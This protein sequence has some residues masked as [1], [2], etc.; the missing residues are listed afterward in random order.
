M[1]RTLKSDKTL[2]L[3][4]LL[5][6]GT[7]M[8]MVYSASAVQA[9]AEYQSQAFFL[10]KQAAWAALGLMTMLV[11]M[12][13]DYRQYRRPAVIWSLVAVAAVLLVAV[14]LFPARNNAQRWI[15]FGSV[16]MQPSE[17]AKLAAILFTVAVLDRRMHRVNHVGYALAP[18]A[19]VAGG[20]ATLIV[21]EPDLGSA[22]VLVGVVVTVVFAAGLSYRYLFGTVLVLVPV[23]GAFLIGSDFRRRRIA[24]FLNPWADPLGDGYQI[25]NSLIAIGSGGLIGKGLGGGLQKL[26][27]IPEPHTDFIY[28]VIAEEFGLIGTTLTLLCFVL[29]AWRGFRASLVAPDRF[30]ALLALGLTSMIVLQACVN[31]SVVISLLPT[32]GIPLPFVSSG[33]SSLI[34]NLIA[35]GV[36]LNISQQATA[37]A[38]ATPARRTDWD[39]RGQEA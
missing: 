34:A 24:T 32:K 10:Y 33:G 16:S 19:I 39:F 28:A 26:Y 11:V 35:M 15:T 25:T 9:M 6:V 23:L 20:L 2:F 18:I 38:G 29:I 8:V 3:A 13:V 17:L 12:R 5:L 37:P 4:T 30:G 7:S 31:V 1:A 22:A 36:L 21:I 14:F 27:Y